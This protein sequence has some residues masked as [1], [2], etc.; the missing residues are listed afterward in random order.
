MPKE[1]KNTARRLIEILLVTVLY[2]ITA[3]IGQVFSIDPGNITPVWIPSGIMLAW[4]ILRGY[5]IWPGIFFGAFL[6]NSWAYFSTTSAAELYAAVFAGVFNGIG[7]T[8]CTIV[9]AMLLQKYFKEST[10]FNSLNAFWGL[11]VFGVVLGPFVSALFGVT[12]LW[13]VDI[14]AKDT[15]T[16][17]LFTWW[18]GDGIGV[19]LLTPL[20]LAFA[21]PEDDLT[22]QP[23]I[24]EIVLFSAAALL[25]PILL[26]SL[27]NNDFLASNSAF[28]LVPILFWAVIRFGLRISFSVTLYFS[29]CLI[30]LESIGLGPFHY[31][32]IF[33]NIVSTQFFVL[34]T[35]SSIFIIGSLLADRDRDFRLLQDKNQ[36]DALTKIFNRQYFDQRLSQE[37]SRQERYKKPFSIIMYDIDFFKKVNDTY[38]HQAGDEVL[39]KLS[40][41]ISAQL[42]DIDILARWGGEEFMIL[43]PETNAEG[44][45]FFAERIRAKV[46]QTEMIPNVFITISLGVVEAAPEVKNRELT[47]I[48]QLDAALYL[49]KNN[50]RNQVQFAQNALGQDKRQLSSP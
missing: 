11:M 1:N 16:F 38:G 29:I 45:A 23:R 8:L 44:A 41:V 48:S 9:A 49:A 47:L 25:Y 7:D 2:L 32:D 17:S 4:V 46:E 28:L 12:S 18:I 42:R 43:L 37:I 33:Y 35:V 20:I 22:F 27:G 36:H 3:R 24:P 15:Y 14:L 21:H 10:P 5:Y 30:W 31:D 26:F 50:G 6:G 39:I 40:S 34:I 13:L 19:L